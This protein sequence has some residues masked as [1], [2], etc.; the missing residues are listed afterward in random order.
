MGL[1]FLISAYFLPVSFDRKGAAAFL[2]D[3]FVRLGIPLVVGYVVF[4]A[5]EQKLDVAHLWFVGHLLVYALL[6]T[7]W[8]VLDLPSLSA[9]MPS[10]RQILAFTLALATVTFAVRTAF[11]VDLWLSLGGILNV[12]VA[13]LP[14]YASLFAIGLMAARGR[15]LERLPAST[16]LLWLRIGLALAALRYAYLLGGDWTP[17]LAGGGFNFGSLMWS[18]WEAFICVGLCVG[19]PVLFRERFAHP[20]R[21]T[22][23]AARHAFGAYVVHVIPVVVGLQFVLA[24]LSVDPLVKFV[25]VTVLG[26]PVSFALAAAV[27]RLGWRTL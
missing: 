21:W 22:Q 6:Y 2:R 10:H 5:L 16:G 1:F 3:R 26:I 23:L 4:S 17:R 18:T 20:G 8:R 27:H 19:L 25:V 9:V 11:P 12:E 24:P 14:Q 15:W 13:H 7:A